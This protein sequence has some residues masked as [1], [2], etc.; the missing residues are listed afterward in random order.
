MRQLNL[1]I[2][3]LVAERGC[4]GDLCEESPGLP[5][6]GH[7]QVQLQPYHRWSPRWWHPGENN[8]REEQNAAAHSSWEMRGKKREKKSKPMEDHSGEDIHTTAWRKLICPQGSCSPWTGAH[9]GVGEKCEGKVVAEKSC[10]R[11][12]TIWDV[13]VSVKSWKWNC[14]FE[15]GRRVRTDWRCFSLSLF[16]IILLCF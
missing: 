8:P 11:L 13:R 1:Q 16:L 14:E 10:Y 12:T 2:Q 7:S 6:D 4:I 3:V 5:H 15:P 9:S